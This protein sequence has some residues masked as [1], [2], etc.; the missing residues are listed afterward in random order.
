MALRQGDLGLLRGVLRLTVIADIVFT[1][2]AAVTEEAGTAEPELIR[3]PKAEA[4]GEGE[5]DKKA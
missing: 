3:K 5:G 1:A 4:E 2:V